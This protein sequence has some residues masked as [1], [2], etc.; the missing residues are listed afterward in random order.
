M[1]KKALV[2]VSL[3]AALGA[4]ADTRNFSITP[5][6]GT[7]GIGGDVAY[8]F[9]DSLKLRGS[10]T[11]FKY[12]GS[13]DAEEIDYDADIKLSGLGLVGDWHPF[14]GAFRLS[15]GLYR[16]DVSF[17]LKAKPKDTGGYVINGENYS[18]DDV[19]AINGKLSWKK[20]A[21]Y[22]GLGFETGFS[23]SSR[24][25]LVFDLGAVRVGKANLDYSATGAAANPMLKAD[26]EKEKQKV[27]DAL[28]KAAW[29][30]VINLG[31]VVRF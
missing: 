17:D 4:Q 26:I 1:L 18:V 3:V 8:R 23:S 15:A 29:Y 27:Q 20:T 30:P 6:A 25:G 11:T 19:G 2:A 16:T 22:V 12:S 10:F 14:E 24:L 9:T 31:L 7:L 5:K 13:K 21:P 28:D